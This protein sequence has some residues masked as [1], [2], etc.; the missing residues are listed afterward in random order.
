[1]I[2]GGADARYVPDGRL[3]FARSGALV[4]VDFDL[5]RLEV[6]GGPRVIREDLL[7][8]PFSGAG[9]FAVA[10]NGTLVYATRDALAVQRGFYRIDR[11]GTEELIEPDLRAYT[12]PRLSPA[13]DRFAATRLDGSM[14][15]WLHDLERGSAERLTHEGHNVWPLWTPAGDRIVFSSNRAGAF[16]LFWKAARGDAP[17]ERLTR[18]EHLQFPGSWSPDGQWLVYSEFHPDTRWD[19]WKLRVDGGR[20]PEP[21]LLTDF[22]E[23]RPTFSPDGTLVAYVSNESGRWDERGR[24]EVY[25]RLWDEPETRLRVSPAGGRDPAWS[26]DG[27]TLYFREGNRLFAASVRRAPAPEIGEP[28]VVFDDLRLPR[29]ESA[30]VIP[31]Y[32]VA[33]DGSFV[34]MRLVRPPRSTALSVVLPGR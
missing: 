29:F 22:D 9:H 1:V 19:I 28:W 18:S 8:H 15:I 31:A 33:R 27:R 25:V 17:A 3:L 4:E 16:N 10:R 30:D 24:W 23:F 7:T 26:A 6:T 2:R 5:G 34:A 11:S 20:E 21:L 14:Q 13:G 12:T 32:D